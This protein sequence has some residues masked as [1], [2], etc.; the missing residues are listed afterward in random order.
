MS[1]GG[2]VSEF[3]DVAGV[4]DVAEGQLLG[5]KLPDGTRVCLYKQR[6]SIGAVSDT[7]THAE[8]PISEGSLRPDGTIVCGWHGAR[9]DCHTGAVCRPPAT[10]P[11]PVHEVRIENDRVLVGPIA[12]SVNPV[13]SANTAERRA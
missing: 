11:L 13:G 8:Y 10:D 3:I 2:S 5:V 4:S 1:E 12:N 6:G 7:C 9:F